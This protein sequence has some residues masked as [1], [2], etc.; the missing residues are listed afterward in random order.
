MSNWGWAFKEET[1]NRPQT[2]FY[3]SHLWILTSCHPVFW[4]VS[5][6]PRLFH[7]NSKFSGCFFKI[8][9]RRKR[10][11]ISCFKIRISVRNVR[12]G[13]KAIKQQL[14]PTLESQTGEGQVT[15]GLLGGKISTFQIQTV[16]LQFHN[17][18]EKFGTLAKA[19]TI[20]GRIVC[21][22]SSFEKTIGQS[23]NISSASRWCIGLSRTG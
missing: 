1:E 5:D 21:V 18:C 6:K 11:S 22:I 20:V 10:N 2:H 16:Q 9:K 15:Q 23:L 3:L 19:K 12:R 8:K 17:V 7:R 14:I 4:S 13:E